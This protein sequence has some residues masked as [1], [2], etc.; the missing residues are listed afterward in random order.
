MTPSSHAN[1]SDTNLT[2]SNLD[3]ISHQQS[4]LGSLYDAG[5]RSRTKKLDAFDQERI[6]TNT[7]TSSRAASANP[8]RGL[9]HSPEWVRS[10]SSRGERL[11]GENRA[12][13]HETKRGLWDGS[14]AAQGLNTLQDMAFSFVN[15]NSEIKERETSRSWA[16]P[17]NLEGFTGNGKGKGKPKVR[18]NWGPG[19]IC[20]ENTDA[21]LNIGI[22][23]NRDK[24][25][26]ERLK[27]RVL[28]GQ[29]NSTHTVDS[30]GNCKRRTSVAETQPRGTNEEENILVYM[31]HVQPEDTLQG[32]VLKF[33]AQMDVFKKANRLWTGDL[34]QI[35]ERV[36]LPVEACAIKG[37]PCSP[38]N[39]GNLSNQNPQSQ[40][41]S[42]EQIIFTNN[43]DPWKAA[44]HS[45]DNSKPWIHVRWVL[46]DTSTKPVEVVRIP[47]KTLNYFPPRRRK[48][49]ATASTVSTPRI[50][51]EIP[52]YSQTSLESQANSPSRVISGNTHTAAQ[53]SLTTSYFPQPS[54]TSSHRESVC[55][56]ANRLGWL[57]GPGGVGT[58]DKNVRKPGP[59]NDALNTWTS[60]Q[61]PGIAIDS[62]PSTSTLVI[63]TGQTDLYSECIGST[64]SEGPPASHVSGNIGGRLA[65]PNVNLN[66]V[67]NWVRK[68]ATR[69]QV[70]G[71]AR[72][73]AIEMLDGAGSDDGRG[74]E[75]SSACYSSDTALRG[76]RYVIQSSI[77]DAANKS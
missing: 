7:S 60:K 31:H 66:S 76:R 44:E 23:E 69:A 12:F 74:V 73:D 51:S 53:S 4:H 63:D 3:T 43:T 71:T 16:S 57:R 39:Q 65:F 2:I 19:N 48:S 28:E 27:A 38:P 15:G 5:I 34:I 70:P 46:L 14:W 21:G 11:K 45:E 1:T 42:Q 52:T 6:T 50:S 59:A 61:F 75:T 40:A 49:L 18:S 29:D 77:R 33:H 58:M 32:I 9:G 55:G 26:H 35:R 10:T 54:S 37:R 24:K 41:S 47:R 36:F 68:I 62:L 72:E 20:G 8:T 67:E 13:N 22:M 30:M 64:P 17:P 56:A 25:N